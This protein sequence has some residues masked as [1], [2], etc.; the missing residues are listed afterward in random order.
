MLGY[1][2]SRFPGTGF[3]VTHS[4]YG[5]IPLG[6]A[7]AR[8]SGPRHVLI[9]ARRGLVKPSAGYGVVR[10]A[11]DCERLARLWEEKRPLPA[12]RWAQQPWRMFDAGFL[13]LAAADPR[14]PMSLL[15]RVM[16]TIP[17][18]RSVGSVRSC[19]PRPRS[20]SAGGV[21]LRRRRRGAGR[22]RGPG[23]WSGRRAS[24]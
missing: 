16:T 17:L 1:L 20:C 8:T 11:E 18:V 2:R 15:G 14:L 3:T 19:G 9:G 24:S 21:S 23:A 10:I 22:R 7:P 6:F 12:S 13:R 5:T 4:E